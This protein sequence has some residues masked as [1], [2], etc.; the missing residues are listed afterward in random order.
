MTF[1]PARP[2]GLI[3]LLVLNQLHIFIS[4][5][6]RN[7][8]LLV[9]LGLSERWPVLFSSRLPNSVL[10]QYHLTGARSY[11]TGGQYLLLRTPLLNSFAV[12]GVGWD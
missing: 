2:S 11:Y 10:T 4:N 3:G 9:A 7:G 5:G 1:N 12:Y 8:F 6:A